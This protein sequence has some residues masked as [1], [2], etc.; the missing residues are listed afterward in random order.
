MRIKIVNYFLKVYLKESRNSDIRNE[1]IYEP[2]GRP[3]LRGLVSYLADL[4]PDLSIILVH[5]QLINIIGKYIDIGLIDIP[6]QVS[7]YYEI[8]VYDHPYIINQPCKVVKIALPQLAASGV[9]SMDL[10]EELREFHPGLLLEAIS[11]AEGL[12]A[13]LLPAVA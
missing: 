10:L 3:K 6:K 12:C 2:E 1:I 5:A 8:T 7:A 13:A 9:S 11:A 4:E